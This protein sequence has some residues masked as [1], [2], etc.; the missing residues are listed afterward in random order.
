VLWVKGSGSDLGSIRP[1]QFTGLRL[2]DVLPLLERD[3]MSDEELI[4]YYEHAVLKPGQ[5]RAS[6]ETPLHS[7]LPFDQVDHTHPDAIIALC[8][9]PEGPELAQRLWGGR[10]IW[11]D[12]ERPSSATPGPSIRS[13]APPRRWPIG[14]TGGASSRLAP[15]RQEWIVRC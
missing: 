15:T 10:A 3:V 7:M 6:I 14:R 1:E 5:P 12:Y 8:A 9:V 2:D 13:A 11:V 4:A